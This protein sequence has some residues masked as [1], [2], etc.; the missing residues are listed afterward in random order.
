MAFCDHSLD[1][2][3]LKCKESIRL[4]SGQVAWPIWSIWTSGSV[5]FLTIIRLIMVHFLCQ[6]TQ[7]F[8]S[9]ILHNQSCMMRTEAVELLLPHFLLAAVYKALS[10]CLIQIWASSRDICLAQFL[11]LACRGRQY[12]NDKKADYVAI[13]NMIYH[14]ISPSK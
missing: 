1:N 9:L 13:I 4:L 12:S 14:I 6:D 5:F 3:S 10:V 8:I 2:T 7:M 11:S